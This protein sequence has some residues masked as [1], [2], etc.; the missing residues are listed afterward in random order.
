[1]DLDLDGVVVRSGFDLVLLRS[2]RDV[3]LVRSVRD[4]VLV[5]SGR[6]ADFRSVL[7]LRLCLLFD[8]LVTS[9]LLELKSGFDELRSELLLGFDFEGFGISSNSVTF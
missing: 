1:M 9:D 2:V 7:E 5:R 8:N 4:V 3:V 6:D